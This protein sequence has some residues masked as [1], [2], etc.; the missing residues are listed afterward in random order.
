M[1]ESP[2]SAIVNGV[3]GSGNIVSLSHCATRLRFELADGSK[4]DK[5][6]LDK[7]KG[8]LGT[9]PQG[10]HHFQVVIGGA[11][12]SVYNDIMALPEMSQGS[13][14]KTDSDLKA[15]L[16]SGGV[17]GKFTLVDRLFEFLSDS[18]RPILG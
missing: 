7:T 15:E 16:R 18:F 13:K 5:A 17:R 9:V 2:A 11:V 4:V 14:A 3:G 1:A 12:Q 6:A 10:D 8:V